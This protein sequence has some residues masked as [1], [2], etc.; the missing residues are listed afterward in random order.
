MKK[1]KW[2]ILLIAM[3]LTVV[4]TITVAGCKPADTDETPG[5]QTIIPTSKNVSALKANLLSM[6]GFTE[7]ITVEGA[8]YNFREQAVVLSIINNFCAN[9]SASSMSQ[10]KIDAL[11][12]KNFEIMEGPQDIFSLGLTEDDFAIVSTALFAAAVTTYNNPTLLDGAEAAAVAFINSFDAEKKTDFADYAKYYA[13]LESLQR[14][15]ELGEE[16]NEADIT[17]GKALLES[18]ELE[19]ECDPNES[20]MSQFQQGI[21]G[22]IEQKVSE[23]RSPLYQDRTDAEIEA[24]EV[25]QLY[26]SWNFGTFYN[27]ASEY[28]DTNPNADA[29]T[30]AWLGEWLA[31][32]KIV[33][34]AINVTIPATVNGLSKEW[35]ESV[36]KELKRRE[37]NFDIISRDYEYYA[38]VFY[39]SQGLELFSEEMIFANTTIQPQI[40]ALLPSLPAFAYR[41]SNSLLTED[42]LLLFTGESGPDFSDLDISLVV[43]M[44][45]S[46]KTNLTELKAFVLANNDNLLS[47]KAA[48]DNLVD[49]PDQRFTRQM[50]MHLSEILT[51]VTKTLPSTIDFIQTVL[52]PLNAETITGIYNSLNIENDV[53]VQMNFGIYFAKIAENLLD[54]FATPTVFATKLNELIFDYSEDHIQFLLIGQIG[55]MVF[56]KIGE[57]EEITETMME[58]AMLFVGGK[59]LLLKSKESSVPQIIENGYDALQ[60]LLPEGAVSVTITDFA[61]NT[62][63]QAYYAAVNTYLNTL[64]EGDEGVR[65][66]LQTAMELFLAPIYDEIDTDVITALAAC[67]PVTAKD[68][69]SE[70]IAYQALI[71]PMTNFMNMLVDAGFFDHGDEIMPPIEDEEGLKAVFGGFVTGFLEGMLS[72]EGDDFSNVTDQLTDTTPYD[73]SGTEDEYLVKITPTKTGT[74][75]L[76]FAV[77]DGYYQNMI[78]FNP[79]GKEVSRNGNYEAVEFDVYAGMNYFFSFASNNSGTLTMTVTPISYDA[80]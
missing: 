58:N 4:I 74:I 56:D 35:I 40:Q 6:S 32:I 5:D 57:P 73:I 45:D 39:Q 76:T 28:Q 2:I 31:A 29:S 14:I 16:V 70:D 19:D 3:L 33:D 61:N 52:A 69:Y 78:L 64:I 11:A 54:E 47:L 20:I 36:R 34:P 49:N 9:I 80:D 50:L 18:I 27:W 23:A 17:A 62:Q 48:I 10:A 37:R 53:E 21:Y 26:Q 22:V 30:L 66:T 24:R 43:A 60:E 12:T 71:T 63:V 42:I 13:V 44:V 46:M 72:E 67:A 1:N 7:E 79:N 77:G 38:Q 25:A 75:T 68:S 41:A 59:D 8:D 65:T 51:A 15:K 55:D